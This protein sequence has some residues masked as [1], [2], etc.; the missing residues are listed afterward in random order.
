MRVAESSKSSGS[1]WKMDWNPELSVVLVVVIVRVSSVS[2]FVGFVGIV[3]LEVVV[4][5]VSM[6]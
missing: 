5:N 6:K 2:G 4:G 3:V 1:V